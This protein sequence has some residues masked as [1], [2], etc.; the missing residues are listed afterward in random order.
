MAA[1]Y[2][3][4]ARQEEGVLA[5]AQSRGP[6]LHYYAVLPQGA[7]RAKV[8]LLHGYA[9]YGKR[10]SHVAAAWAERGIA[11]FAIDMRGHGLSGGKRGYCES[12]REFLDDAGELAKLVQDRAQGTPAFLFGHS[13]GAL[14]GASMAIEHPSPWR[15]LLLSGPYIGLAM[16]VPRVKILA[17]KVASRLVP[18]FSQPS[19]LQG[20]DMTHDAARARAY[21]ADPLCFKGTTARWFTESTAAQDRLLARAPALTMPLYVVMGSQDRVAKVAR[22]RAFFD[23]AGSPDKTWDERPGLF[24]EV[25]NEPEWRSIADRLAD[26]MADHAR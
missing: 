14:V 10:Y 11:T 3:E 18:A 21:D 9:D 2:E 16:D 7:P 12:F 13:F 20:S 24:H 6:E 8:G 25:L 23:A 1:R 4:K 22:A 5:R 17:G 19:G 15:G 26:W